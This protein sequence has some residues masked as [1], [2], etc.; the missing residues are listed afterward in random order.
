[1]QSA[2]TSTIALVGALCFVCL[3]LLFL[4]R[5]AYISRLGSIIETAYWG[6]GMFRYQKWN[7][8]VLRYERTCL[9]WYRAMSLWP[10]S[11]R[12]FARRDILA[13]NRE[14]MQKATGA[15]KPVRE[16]DCMVTLTVKTA[17]GGQQTEYLLMDLAAYHGFSAWLEAAPAGS[18]L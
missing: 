8:G 14:V 11:A 9:R 5:A 1:M 12:T 4:A 18:E 17:N 6:P 3:G 13:V 10:A 7:Y 15:I 16:F 2:S